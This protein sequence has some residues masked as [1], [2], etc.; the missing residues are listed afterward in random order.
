MC[1]DICAS[2]TTSKRLRTLGE[3]AASVL[4]D[5]G[6]V[7]IYVWMPSSYSAIAPHAIPNCT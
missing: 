4:A 3:M 2:V 6:A 7:F 1:D 5:T